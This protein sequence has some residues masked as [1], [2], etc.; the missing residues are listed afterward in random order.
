MAYEVF[1]WRRRRTGDNGLCEGSRSNQGILLPYRP[2][3]HCEPLKKEV[4]KES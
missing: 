2:K 4:D 1:P 3:T